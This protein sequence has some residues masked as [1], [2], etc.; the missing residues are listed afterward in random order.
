VR[1]DSGEAGARPC[2]ARWTTPVCPRIDAVGGEVRALLKHPDTPRTLGGKSDMRRDI[3]GTLGLTAMTA[4]WLF[5]AGCV[6]ETTDTTAPNDTAESS[7]ELTVLGP[8]PDF[9]IIHRCG[10]HFWLQSPSAFHFDNGTAQ[11]FQLQGLFDGDTSTVTHS[12]A[13]NPA[14]WM[15]RT[16]VPNAVTQDPVDNNGSIVMAAG[17]PHSQGPSTHYWR[18]DFTS[19]VLG[20]GWQNKTDFSYQI[21]E[22]ATFSQVYGQ[23]VVE[24]VKCDGTTS[25]FREVDAQGNPVFC[26]AVHGQWT[27]CTT[28]IQFSNVDYIKRVHVN[29]FGPFAGIYEGGVYIDDV[30]AL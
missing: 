26:P 22:Q 3:I 28:H 27:Q 25:F 5:T 2:T 11:G 8:R 9:E 10:V 30:Q 6:A 21:L 18:A 19:P 13:M 12:I 14:F 4:G 15:D 23:L 17:F 1:G 7:S 29:V 24:V 16:N 20:G